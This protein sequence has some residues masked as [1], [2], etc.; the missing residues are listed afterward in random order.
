MDY[1]GASCHSLIWMFSIDPKGFIDDMQGYHSKP[2]SP[3]QL[4]QA[5]IDLYE[6]SHTEAELFNSSLSL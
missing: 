2:F 1:N 3:E 6:H 4:D 5:I